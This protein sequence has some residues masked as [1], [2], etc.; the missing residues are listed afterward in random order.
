MSTS[1]SR[2]RKLLLTAA[3]V[4]TAVVLGGPPLALEVLYR[5]TLRQLGPPPAPPSPTASPPLAVTAFWIHADGALPPSVEPM[6]AWR[7]SWGLAWRLAFARESLLHPSAGERVASRA[8]RA[9][10]TAG[11]RSG[12]GMGRW[13]SRFWSATIWMTRNRS[14]PLLIQSVIDASYYGRGAI[15]LDK[16]ADAFFG[17][18]PDDLAPHEIALLVALTTSPGHLSGD[19][20]P[21]RAIAARNALL[22]KLLAAGALPRNIHDAAITRG[23]GIIPGR[24]EQKPDEAG[25]GGP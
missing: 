5:Y 3:G 2:R 17:R 8:A 4:V 15:G 24:C 22:D 19:C 1:P 12:G 13:H 14:A 18:P 9:W 11:D 20:H 6:S 23:L 10:I 16:A 21:E 7:W 25:V